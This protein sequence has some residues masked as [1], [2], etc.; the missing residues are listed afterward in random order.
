VACLTEFALVP[1]SSGL[2]ILAFGSLNTIG[3]MDIAVVIPSFKVRDHILSVLRSIGPEVSRIYVVDDQCP[4]FSGKF[5]QE[6]CQ[7]PRVEVIYNKVNQG[8]GGATIAG[9]RRALLEGA[10]IIVKIDGDGQMDPAAIP[11]LVRPIQ[12]GSADYTKGN[13][14]YALENLEGMP[15]MRK[16]GNAGLSF[17][18]KVSSGYWQVMDPANGYTAIHAGALSLLPLAKI[19][20]RYFFESDMLFRLNTIRAVVREIPM[21]AI[22]GEEKSNLS[23]FK[24]LRDFPAKHLCRFV[25]RVCYSYILRDFNVCS[26]ELLAGVSLLAFGSI[27]G[28]YN[29]YYAAVSQV[30]TPTGTI[31][32]AVLPII[33]GVQLLLAAISTDV[34]NVPKE[35]L[36]EIFD[37]EEISVRPSIPE[38][39]VAND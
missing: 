28:A 10:D 17:V 26:V 37:F 39:R 30:S 25:K 6:Q 31:M 15:L 22:Y 24:V 29:W 5:V 27:F 2:G 34:I 18:S 12:K 16:I 38:Q 33:V 4:Q 9:Y 14:F 23:I 35:P 11:N 32:L 36:Q 3:T 20:R 7:D 13:R 21:K 8:V 19:E 1:F